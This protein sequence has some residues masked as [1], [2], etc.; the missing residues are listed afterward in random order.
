MF[1]ISKLVID[2][3]QAKNPFRAYVYSIVRNQVETDDI[4][5]D[6][7]IKMIEKKDQYD[8]TKNI[9]AWT[10]G[11]IRLQ[12]LKW[13]QGKAREKLIFSEDV[14]DAIDET[15][16]TEKTYNELEDRL[17]KMEEAL[18]KLTKD[19]YNILRMKYFENKKNVEIAEHLGK[20]IAAVEMSLTRARRELKAFMEM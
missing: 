5:Q 2:F 13:R 19:S 4:L 7:Y 3:R 18:P 16:I 17:E 9:K 6:A 15:I 1:D 10:M 14:I 20:S 11:F 12:I 8:N